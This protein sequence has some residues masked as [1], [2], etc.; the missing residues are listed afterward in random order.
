MTSGV[1]PVA[2]ATDISAMQGLDRASFAQD[3][4]AD[5]FLNV[6]DKGLDR[7]A[8]RPDMKPDSSALQEM[9]EGYSGPVGAEKASILAGAE[10]RV[11][12]A[13]GEQATNIEDRLTSLYFELTNYQVAWKIVQSLQR[14]MSQLLRGS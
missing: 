2:G 12:Q 8:Q 7:L 10:S 11:E 5:A 4:G 9:T 6:F 3:G 14:D 1:S 13:D